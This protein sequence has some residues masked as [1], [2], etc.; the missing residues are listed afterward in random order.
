MQPKSN[1]ISHCSRKVKE[2]KKYLGDVQEQ[3]GLV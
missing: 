1:S 3:K 2:L